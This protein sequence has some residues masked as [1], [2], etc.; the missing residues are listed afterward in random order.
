MKYIMAI[1]EGTTGIRAIIFDH[2]GNIVSQA[3]EE[4]GQ[5]FPRTGWCEQDAGEVWRKCI[6]VM[7]GAMAAGG[8]GAGDI[9][10]IGITTQR[11][12]NLLWERKS[13]RPI[14]NAITWHD[15]RTSDLCREMDGNGKIRAIKALGRL[16]RGISR[17]WEGIRMTPTGAL[18]VSASNLSFTPASALAHTAWMLENVEGARERAGKGEILFGTMD[19]WLIWNLTNGRVH[20]TDFSNASSTG[21]F[22]SFALKW[23][24]LFLDTFGIPDAILPEVRDT[25]GDFGSV[26]GK[27]LGREIPIMSAVADQQSALFADGCFGPGDVKCTNGTGSFIDMNVGSRPPASLHKLLPH[28]AWSID[29]KVT[30]MLEGMMNTTGSAVQWLK[31]VNIIDDVKDTDAIAGSVESTEGVYF[32]PAFTG[33]SSPYWDP[34][35]CGIAVGL[36]RKTG[37]EHIVRAV[38]EGI[39]YRCRDILLAM[40]VDTGLK[41]S[42]IKADGGASS[43]DFLLQ[44][45]ADMLNVKVERPAILDSTALGAAYL[46]GLASGYWQSKEEILGK[47]KVDRIFEPRMDEKKRQTL[48]NGWKRAIERSFE[49]HH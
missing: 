26:D 18:L 32:V 22:D 20:A 9:E 10:A 24:K 29:G 34:H 45:M 42:S 28:I 46:A 48:Y 38:L 33:L 44:F 2:G 8:L 7:K 36:S 13:G 12:T 31:D 17:V 1:D 3:Y 39:V 19:T 11:S 47:R 43:N 4:I 14:Y 23:S 40:E 30:Y 5:I 37:R 35:A 21:I 25:S 16:V 15:T 6:S 27:I 49:W 41:I